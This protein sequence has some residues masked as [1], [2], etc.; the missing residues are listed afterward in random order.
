VAEHYLALTIDDVGQQLLLM[1]ALRGGIHVEDD[2]EAVLKLRLDPSRPV[3]P[4]QLIPFL[5]E[6]GV[7]GKAL[8]S[9]ARF[10]AALPRV[11]RE[12]DATLIEVNP[13]AVTAAGQ[14]VALDCKMSVDE[15]A[16]G[17][18]G[19][20]P[21]W[22]SAEFAEVGSSALE[23]RARRS[24]FTFVEME[25][26]IAIISGGA[27]LGMMLVDLFAESGYRAANFC[28][29][30]GGSG[31][32]EFREMVDLVLER[33][34]MPDVKAIAVYFT[35]SATSLKAAVMSVTNA[36]RSKPPAK[37][38]VVGF[39]AAGPAESEMTMAQAVE[40]FASL[41]YVCVSDPAA[42]VDAVGEALASRAK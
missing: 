15:Y 37:P 16:A 18:H 8:G 29:L 17:R 41:G 22:I 28:D 38:L 33:A 20:W 2:P 36:I 30:L 12:Q 32:R 14:V 11:L 24:G 34:T 31:E 26:D 25:G 35:L 10:A 23:A 4:H 3:H 5:R 7:T 42:L 1:F 40:T 9:V 13:L 27:G 19:D 21:S 6:A 39:G